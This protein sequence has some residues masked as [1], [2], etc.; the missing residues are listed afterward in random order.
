[1]DL[2]FDSLFNRQMGFEG[3]VLES[4]EE[5]EVKMRT[6]VSE[7]ACNLYGFAHG[8]FLFTLCDTLAGLVG[9]TLGSLVV[10]QQASISYL[11]RAEKDEE[12]FLEGKVIHN[13]RSSKVVET[14]IRNAEDVL[15]C[16]AT[17][18]LFPVAAVP[19]E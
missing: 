17:F 4:M 8:G 19:K 18:Q 15:L 13:G 3:C 6:R 10:T 5:G 7:S 11:K 14:S 12:L 9:Y 1:M 2:T 16:R